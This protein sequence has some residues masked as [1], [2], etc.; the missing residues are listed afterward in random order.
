MLMKSGKT[1]FKAGIVFVLMALAAL[2]ACKNEDGEEE[3]EKNS[4]KRD[5]DEPVLRPGDGEIIVEWKAV[6][7]VT[8]YTVYWSESEDGE[9]AHSSEYISVDASDDEILTTTISDLENDTKYWVWVKAKAKAE[10][11][12]IG[13]KPCTPFAPPP[14]EADGSGE[15]EE[16]GDGGKPLPAAPT[17]TAVERV[18]DTSNGDR[19]KVSWTADVPATSYNVYWS[20]TAT[21]GQDT[22]EFPGEPIEADSTEAYIPSGSGSGEHDPQLEYYVWVVAVD[23]ES[24]LS[25][26]PSAVELSASELAY[27]VNDSDA[28]EAAKSALA[29]S[30]VKNHTVTVV[31]DTVSTASSITVRN[32]GSPD[33]TVTITGAGPEAVIKGGVDLLTIEGGKVTL[34]ELTLDGGYNS[35]VSVSGGELVL[36]DGAIVT[37]SNVDGVRISGG[38]VFTMTGG[39]I[40]GNEW[41]GVKM[42]GGEFEMTGGEIAIN[43]GSGVSTDISAVFKK[44]GGTVY[45]RRSKAD[46]YANRSGSINGAKDN[47]EPNDN[48]PPK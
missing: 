9:E 43:G 21:P 25:S 31:N 4:V 19:I 37:G 48:Y 1:T 26:A 2:A 22:A 23:G 34:S 36:Q 46:D 45:G 3:L 35:T 40:S 24:D 28:L 13:K 27:T 5:I 47:Y 15:S 20:T 14:P 10:N 38:G 7:G 32:A 29:E 6:P 12:T 17:I 41:N 16:A 39:K 30:K 8:W 11:L 44:T 33:K 18:Y 42:T